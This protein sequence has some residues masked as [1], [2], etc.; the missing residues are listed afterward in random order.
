M[1]LEK[2]GKNKDLRVRRQQLAEGCG[3]VANLSEVWMPF[4]TSHRGRFAEAF[5]SQR[6]C[7]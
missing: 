3:V 1:C 7:L 4:V 5:V 2:G 6:T